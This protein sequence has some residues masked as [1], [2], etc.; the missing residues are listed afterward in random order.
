VAFIDDLDKAVGMFSTGMDRLNQTQ[1]FNKASE[2]INE[3]NTTVTNEMEK[4]TQLNEAS[5]ELGRG[6]LQANA[7]ISKIQ[8]A[9]TSFGAA[10][11]PGAKEQIA[12]GVQSGDD[13][14]LAKGLKQDK[15]NLQMAHNN[16]LELQRATGGS[17]T[18]KLRNLAPGELEK[19]NGIDANV[20]QGTDLLNRMESD[21]QLSSWVSGRIPFA[22]EARAV[23][24]TKFAAF[25]A[26]TGRFFDQY[27][28]MITGAAAS[29]KEIAILEKNIP[30]AKDRPKVFRAKMRSFLKTYK[31]VRARTLANLGKAGRD[32]SG[33]TAT[34]D[35]RADQR[36][37][38][39]PTSDASKL[40]TGIVGLTGL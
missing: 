21:P 20:I 38:D 31:V 8:A 11:L 10:P 35:L 5:Q 19:I 27:R 3:I 36:P 28:K 16:A 24:D 15:A 33:F 23:F 30:Q 37:V 40:S 25:K 32:I 34:E 17:S 18:P 6:L 7:P 13:A 2:R 29:V 4:R 14:T 9:F 1:A 22:A 12:V 26:D 39:K